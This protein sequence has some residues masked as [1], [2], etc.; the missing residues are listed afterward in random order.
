VM[1]AAIG[2]FAGPV[3]VTP[4]TDP[5]SSGSENAIRIGSWSHIPGLPLAGEI[6]ATVGGVVS[7]ASSSS[8]P[9]DSAEQAASSASRID[10]RFIGRRVSKHRTRSQRG[11]ATRRCVEDLL[12]SIDPID[13][14]DRRLRR[15][16][17]LSPPKRYAAAMARTFVRVELEHA[18]SEAPFSTAMGA[19]GF[20]QT[21]T[22]R[23]NRKSLQ[24]PSGT[25]LIE[26]ANPVQALALTR[27]AAVASNVRVRIFCVPAD[28][29]VRFGNLQR[30]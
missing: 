7:P 8:L 22:G 17:R 18:D 27:E 3:S 12:V 11:A 21:V 30:V 16:P 19:R 29:D 15:K 13:Q 1:S 4:A 20:V 23:K 26:R 25:Y 24:L 5:G 9:V 6:D 2:S 10:D 14:P 28:G